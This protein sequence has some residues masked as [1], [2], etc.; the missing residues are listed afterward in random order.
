MSVFSGSI[1]YL[2]WMDKNCDFC[3]NNDNCDFEKAMFDNYAFGESNVDL[4]KEF[5]GEEYNGR[6]KN[7]IKRQK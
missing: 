4:H 3:K 7:C 6:L 5:T 2:N 1:H